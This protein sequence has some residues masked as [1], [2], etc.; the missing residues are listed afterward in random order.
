M[1]KKH[2]ILIAGMAGASLGSEIAKCLHLANKYNIYGCDISD[3][4]YGH[5]MPLFLK[6]FTVNNTNYIDYIISIC[7][8]YKIN[9]IIPGGEEPMNILSRENSKLISNN[10]MLASNSPS[11]IEIFSDKNK[12]FKKLHELGFY[13]PKTIEAK[14]EDDLNDISFPCIVKPT[15]GTGGSDSVFLVANKEECLVYVELLKRNGRN[16]IIQEYIPLDEGEFTIG[17]L[18]LTN[19][20]VVGCVVMKRL[21]NSKLSISYKSKYGL[22]SSGY[23]Q[24]LIEDFPSLKEE[25]IHIARSVGSTGPLNIQARVKDGRL[26]PFEINP[27]F[28]AST[29]LR[30]KAGFNE[31]DFYLQNMINNTQHFEYEMNFGYYLRSFEEVYVPLKEINYD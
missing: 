19:K 28:S 14:N 17:V 15:T 1:T 10:I 16:T 18:S 5:F 30:A 9:Y 24:G 7:R 20:D 13:I 21:F 26:I 31:V 4:A 27:R 11:I 22:I 29:Y 23:S 12:T 8:E 6:T 25:A 2:N 3:L